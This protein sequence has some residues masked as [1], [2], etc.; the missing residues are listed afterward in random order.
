MKIVKTI[1]NLRDPSDKEPDEKPDE[2]HPAI[3]GGKGSLESILK[4]DVQVIF[5][6]RRL[7][8]NVL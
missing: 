1:S 8:C 4:N 6:N 3:G 5:L 2:D 7:Y